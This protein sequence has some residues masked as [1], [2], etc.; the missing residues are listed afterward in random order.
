MAGNVTN[1]LE[2][3]I[4]AETPQDRERLQL[5]VEM[6]AAVDSH[7]DVAV[8]QEAGQILLL[9]PDESYI[10]FTIG[11][12]Q[13]ELGVRLSVGPPQIGYREALGRKVEIDYTHKKQS[14]GSGQ[15]ARIKIVFEPG[16]P[17]S[18]YSFESKIVGGSVP[19]EF[20]PGV[21]KG[22][23]ASRETGVLAGFPVID[24]K[25]T[26]VDGNYHDVDSSMLA[27]EN[28]RPRRFQGRP[29]EGRLQ[30]A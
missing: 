28:R 25:A 17:G 10:E 14:G 9:G 4:E 21:E 8:R 18:G 7:V 23:E 22:L 3:V 13:S 6:L 30:A 19:K 27:F 24:F 1:P 2:V 12:L 15:F 29:S 11:R 5:A 16:E 20:I 26:L